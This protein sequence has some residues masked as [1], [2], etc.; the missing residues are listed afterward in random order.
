MPRAPHDAHLDA[1]VDALNRNDLSEVPV[2]VE[3]LAPSVDALTRDFAVLCIHT[4]HIKELGS[5]SGNRDVR[6]ALDDFL[7]TMARFATVAH[8]PTQH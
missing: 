5:S 3:L 6:L 4:R 8:W 1:L 7:T 2:I